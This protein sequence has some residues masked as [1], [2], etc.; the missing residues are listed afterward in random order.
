V[1][2]LTESLSEELKGSGVTVTALCPGVT[3]TPMVAGATAANAKLGQLPRFLV[4]DAD[5]VAAEG[6]RACLRGDV[7][8]VPGVINLA[9]VLAAR[10]TPKWLLRAVSGV[11]A[12]RSV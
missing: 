2:S 7:I 4:G 6:V 5:A 9:G 1:L 3:A 12:R 8:A 10:A 11:V